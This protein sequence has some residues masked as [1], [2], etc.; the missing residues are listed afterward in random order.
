MGPAMPPSMCRQ[1]FVEERRSDGRVAGP[2]DQGASMIMGHSVTQWDAWYDTHFHSR[3]G[4]KAVNE[5]VSWREALLQ[6]ADAQTADQEAATDPTLSAP[7]PA[8][9]STIES[10]TG[11]MS[12]DSVAFGV[13]RT[14]SLISLMS[15]WLSVRVD[16]LE[17]L[18]LA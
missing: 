12:C 4:Q 16:S 13:L 2:S 11:Y 10:D 18:L 8:S 14:L 9:P 17:L 15:R 6:D 1:V 7:S 3:L 5:M